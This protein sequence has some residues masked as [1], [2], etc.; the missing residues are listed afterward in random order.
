VARLIHVGYGVLLAQRDAMRPPPDGGGMKASRPRLPTAVEPWFE[1]SPRHPLVD[2]RVREGIEGVAASLET[3]GGVTGPN[4]VVDREIDEIVLGGHHVASGTLAPED[5]SAFDRQC[6]ARIAVAAD[7]L[8]RPR[9]CLVVAAVRG[10]GA[11]NRARVQTFVGRELVAEDFVYGD[12]RIAALVELR[13]DDVVFELRL[14]LAGPEHD[15]KLS[16]RGVHG[17]LL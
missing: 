6:T 1:L 8:A 12:D 10:L 11:E 7:G 13:G 14:R 16:I 5:L 2:S 9:E 15:A 3:F 4:I 17:T